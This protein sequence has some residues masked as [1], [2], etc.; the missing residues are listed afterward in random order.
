MF[1]DSM[2][3]T[4]GGMKLNERSPKRF[5]VLLSDFEQVFFGRSE[6]ET[7]RKCREMKKDTLKKYLFKMVAILF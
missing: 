5:Q 4:D 1:S 2:F 3:Q 7:V 6:G